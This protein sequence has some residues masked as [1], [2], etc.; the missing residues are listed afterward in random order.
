MSLRTN[1]FQEYLN[2]IIYWSIVIL[3]FS[4]AICPA[5]MNG[6]MAILIVAFL[7]KKTLKK[8][9]LFKKNALSLPVLFLF[10]ITCISVINTVCLKDSL[11]GGV[12]RLGHYILILFIMAEEVRDKRHIG[13]ILFSICAGIALASVN[14]IFQVAFG[15]DFIRGYKPILNIGLTRATASLKTRIF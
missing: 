10:A 1:Q 2:R 15:R 13:Y 4:I 11:R 3:P 8:E 9:W 6:F 7:V 5:M 14:G 12:F